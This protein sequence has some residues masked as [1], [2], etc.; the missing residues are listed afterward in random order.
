IK[1]IGFGNFLLYPSSYYINGFPGGSGE[2]C[3]IYIGPAST[4]GVS[5]GGTDGTS[6]YQVMLFR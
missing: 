3:A 4:S 5:S 2:Y 1:A 6:L